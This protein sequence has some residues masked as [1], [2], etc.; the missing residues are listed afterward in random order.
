[1]REIKFK[2]LYE[3]GNLKEWHYFTINEFLKARVNDY[4]PFYKHWC[5]FTGLKD[6]NG[7]EIYEGDIVKT[8]E[9]GWIAQVIYSRD[10]FICV[11]EGSVFSCMCN[12]ENFEVLGNIYESPDLVK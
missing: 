9:A 7:K 12:W 3:K 1:M 4:A 11:K 8:D 6:K 2:G 10:S 5:Q